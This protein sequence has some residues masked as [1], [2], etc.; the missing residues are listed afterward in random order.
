MLVNVDKSFLPKRD[1]EWF[2]FCPRDRKYPNGLRTNRATISG[3]WKAT[4]KD[5][6]IAC[7][8]SLC[9]L[10]KTLV[11]YRGRA[12]GGERMDWVMHV[13]R[14]CENLHEGSSNFV[15]GFALCRVIKR[16]VNG[17]KA[18]DL[19]GECK[20]KRCHSS[21]DAFKFDPK[22]YSDKVLDSLEENSS[23]VTK[24][25]HRSTDS[26]PIASPD[27]DREID[28]AER[29]FWESQLVSDATKTSL[30]DRGISSS[31]IT[32]GNTAEREASLFPFIVNLIE[33]ESVVVDGFPGSGSL[34]AFPSPA[35]YMGLYV[36][37][38]DITYQSLELDAPRDPSASHSGTETWNSTALASVCRQA[39]EGEDESL[40]LHEDN[41]VVVI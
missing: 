20:A 30:V 31:T 38:K 8:P 28:S 15:G 11:F 33:E 41:L 19:H 24:V 25:S 27:A 1:M 5:R 16:N 4:G 12:P 13:Y 39:G 2:F 37:A 34:L 40:W 21:S 17:M 36:N 22:G 14:L 32:I 9:A 6:K 26:I 18:G 35:H 7:E 23:R 3:Y 29:G 10:R